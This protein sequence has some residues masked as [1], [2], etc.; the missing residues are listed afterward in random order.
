MSRNF[1]KFLTHYFPIWLLFISGLIIII[2]SLYLLFFQK[3]IINPKDATI[4]FLTFSDSEDNNIE[5][6]IIKEF[7]QTKKQVKLTYV[8]GKNI[9]FPYIGFA[10][11]PSDQRKWN[12]KFYDELTVKVDPRQTHNFTLL[13]WTYLDGFSD[14]LQNLTWRIFEKDF[15]M[16]KSGE[17]K[18]SINNFITPIW[19]FGSHNIQE[20]GDRSSLSQMGEIHIQSHPLSPKGEHLRIVFYEIILS[21]SLKQISPFLI[22]G[23]LLFI[24][25]FLIQNRLKTPTPYYKPLNID[26]SNC[27][28][29]DDL[30]EYL[31]KEY[32]RQD[33]TINKTSI[34]TGISEKQI[35][36]ILKSKFK[37]SFK[38]YLTII[39]ME[40]SKRLLLETDR[41]I[42]EI[43]NLIGYKHPTTFTRIFRET[44][45]VSPKV[46]REQN[47]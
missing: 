36:S 29:M 26:N 33:L 38:E 16:N 45:G 41:N 19:W 30:I 35:R 40:E 46:F 11:R 4:T 3:V 25:S 14:S 39:R 28:F 32:Y 15:T 22:L 2:F 6:S 1:K 47:N 18:L 5:C 7:E 13:L 10:M 37:N 44:Y 34:E 17:F 21:H 12:C 9:E 24:S 20:N 23:I 8:I 31:A 42:S 27:D 43:S